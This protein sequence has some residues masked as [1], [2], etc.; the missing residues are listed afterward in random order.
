MKPVAFEYCRPDNLEEALAALAEFG[1]DAV[2]M[3][4][5]LSL[6]AMLN[7][8]MVRP[9]AVINI[10]R[11]AEFDLIELSGA[12]LHTGPLVRQVDALNST[13]IKTTVPLLSAALPSVGHYQT[14][15]RGTLAGSM[16]HADPSAEIPLC[17]VVLGG[18]VELMSSRGRRRLAAG[19]FIQGALTTRRES[20]EMI[21]GLIWPTVSEPTSV[22]FFEIAERHGDFAIAAAAAWARRDH[23]GD[24]V[25]FG[26]GLGGVED[27]PRLRT[28]T[29]GAAPSD[30]AEF[31]K[32]TAEAF[33]QQ[34]EPM[35][36]QRVSAD[37]RAHIAGHLAAKALNQVLAIASLE[38]KA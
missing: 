24:L 37:Y 15:S 31:A 9:D 7:M 8:R 27:R 36:D 3:S 13:L 20:D 28:G 12:E 4:G 11:I 1:E 19:D 22:A 5:G 30:L 6:G 38:I 34:L 26:L 23:S 18:E 32:N 14:R 10:N 2:L 35:S 21:T 29:T 33:A 25:S 16:A 17:L